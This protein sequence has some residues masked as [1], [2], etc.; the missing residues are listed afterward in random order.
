MQVVSYLSRFEKVCAYINQHLEQPLRLS[1]LCELAHLSEFHFHRQF[2]ALTGMPLRQYIRL[3]RMHK[4][5]FYLM[6]RNHSVQ[7]I[8]EMIGFENAESFSRAFKQQYAQSPTDYRKHANTVPVSV[9]KLRFTSQITEHKMQVEITELP[10]LTLAV[11]EH[12]GPQQHL[13][14]SIAKLIQ[15]RKK[16]GLSPDKSRT[17]NVFYH[18]PDDVNPAEYRIDVGVLT[19]ISPEGSELK[20]KIIPAGRYACLRY[21]GAWHHM[22]SAVEYLY[23]E[24]LTESAEELADFPCFCERINLY[25]ETPE[26]QLITDIYLPLA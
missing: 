7:R 15:W 14:Q 23:G 18:D 25:P 20:Q 4:A 11:I 17:F 26:H 13:P 6:Y 2:S 8:S 21:M 9:Q 5:A 22:R 3:Q 12:Q 1:E 19:D 24:W 16:Q 10:S